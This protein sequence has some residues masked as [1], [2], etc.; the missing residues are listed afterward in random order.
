MRVSVKERFM[1]HVE[2]VTESGCWIWTSYVNSSGYGLAYFNGHTVTAHR[3]SYQMFKGAIPENLCVLHSCDVKCCVNPAH[4]SL[5][6][7]KQNS[8]QMIKRGRVARGK[9]L[10][11]VR[12]HGEAHHHCK[13]TDEI[14]FFIRYSGLSLPTMVKR[15]GLSITQLHRIRAGTAWAHLPVFRGH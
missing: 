6:T 4:L 13:I 7:H 10:S 9:R 5:G 15:Y 3:V 14:A 1:R 12:T 11:D 8:E 2:V